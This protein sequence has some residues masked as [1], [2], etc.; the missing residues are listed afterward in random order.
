ML[1]KE[2]KVDKKTNKNN[3]IVKEINNIF[4]LI[5][6][7][8]DK[9]NSSDDSE[10][11]DNQSPTIKQSPVKVRRPTKFMERKQSE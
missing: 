10:Q 5:I 2:K 3:F 1:Q 6:N 9:S 7:K 4:D 8:E 11:S